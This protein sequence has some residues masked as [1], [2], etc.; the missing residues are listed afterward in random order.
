MSEPSES[1]KLL[2]QEAYRNLRD[3]HLSQQTGEP[4][5][6]EV[7]LRHMS[8]IYRIA[9]PETL[10]P[11]LPLLL[12]IDGRPMTLDKHLP[13]EPMY[14]IRDI[15]PSL[16]LKCA[17][18]VSKTT[19]LAAVLAVTHACIPYLSRL[20]LSPLF[21]QIQRLSN[22]RV[23]PMITQGPIR[24]ALLSD[25]AVDAKQS[26]LRRSF[27]NGGTAHFSFAS[28]SSDRI[29]GI[30]ADWVDIDEVQ[31]LNPDHL[32]VILETMS[33]TSK[34]DGL[35][36]LRLYG[37]PKGMSNCIQVEWEKSSQAEWV[38]KCEPC[39]YYNVCSRAGDL[40]AMTQRAGLSCAKCGRIVASE[41][42]FWTHMVAEKSRGY[43]GY[44]IP[45]QILPMHNRSEGKWSVLFGKKENYPPAKY[46]NEVCGESDESQDSLV[47]KSQL[48]ACC[49]LDW[50]NIE[51]AA[52]EARKKY[53]QVYM[54]VDWGHQASGVLRKVQGQQ[55]VEKGTPSFTAVSIVG[56]RHAKSPEPH[57]IYME[58]FP[59]GKDPDWEAA[60]IRHLVLTFRPMFL[61]H[62]FGGAGVLREHII[63]G[64]GIPSTCQLV[65][66]VYTGSY[67]R[68]PV[69][70]IG[71][72]ESGRGRP[73]YQVD[74]TRTLSFLCHLIRKQ[75]MRF[76]KW[77]SSADT[78]DDFTSLFEHVT[79]SRYGSETLL[80][81]KDGRKTDD[82]VHAINLCCLSHWQAND[83]WL[84]LA[85][86]F[87]LSLQKGV[88]DDEGSWE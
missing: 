7:G 12:R 67:D 57:V 14:R 80:I 72:N 62:D 26:V 50:A 10:V 79:Y 58:R 88:N 70:Y 17:R 78:L 8:T 71:P 27:R 64:K 66:M 85:R 30:S 69:V 56:F 41:A 6:V 83:L 49:T 35:G 51:H 34:F 38:I 52:I 25:K 15:P 36:V 29:R 31:D 28:N 54:G 4:L 21:T 48:E 39:G 68:N 65:P 9:K 60:R 19:N 3:W 1:E 81:G 2:V 45:Q 55:I 40:D 44:H 73:Y 16:V 87:G 24:R 11:L 75:V 53:Q 86:S 20:V 61:A 33:A 42:G 43:A 13:M 63:V 82:I 37:T 23:T 47:T 84:E 22:D 32:P 76:P 18:Q 5:P 77:E 74:R 46:W 59:S